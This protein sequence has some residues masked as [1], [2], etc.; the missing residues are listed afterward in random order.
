MC[1]HASVRADSRTQ[2]VRV[3]ARMYHTKRMRLIVFSSVAS[4]APP[5]FSTLSHKRYDFRNV[6]FD[7][8]YNLIWNISHFKNNSANIVTKRL[9]AKYPLFLADFNET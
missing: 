7:F 8:L 5:H 9:D 2:R 4:L 1:A 6:R 3:G